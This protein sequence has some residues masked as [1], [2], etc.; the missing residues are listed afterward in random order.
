MANE[1]R[2][3]RDGRLKNPRGGAWASSSQDFVHLANLLFEQSA[4]YA[5]SLDGNCS[6]YAL[7]GIPI[8]FA[9][10]RA[11]LIEGNS[12]MYDA[13]KNPAVL[14]AIANS[15]NEIPLLIKQYGIPNSLGE[16]LTLLYEVRNEI[17][18]PA[19]MPAGTDHGTP[20]YLDPLRQ[21]GVLQSTNSETADYTWIAQ[22]ESHRLFTYA[23]EAIE[24]AASLILDRHH[25]S[26]ES[27]AAHLDSYA[28]YRCVEEKTKT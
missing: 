6:I 2:R 16:R 5:R 1:G 7:A 19:H 25:V 17:L 18:H 14:A 11:L 24:E 28:R 22:L 10:I 20:I 8:L 9:A 13:S 15:S 12:G 26:P 21:A 23:F 4:S 3:D 27:K